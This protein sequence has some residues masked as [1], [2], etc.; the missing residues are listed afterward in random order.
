ME[1]RKAF[2]LRVSEMKCS[3]QTQTKPKMRGLEKKTHTKRARE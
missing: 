1:N 2:P 3:I